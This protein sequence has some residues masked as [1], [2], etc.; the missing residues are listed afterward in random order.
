MIHRIIFL[1]A[2]SP[3]RVQVP[4]YFKLNTKRTSD[5]CPFCIWCGCSQRIRA[6]KLKTTDNH[7][8]IHAVSNRHIGVR[9]KKVINIYTEQI[10]YTKVII[11]NKAS[12]IILW[13]LYCIIRQIMVK[14]NIYCVLEVY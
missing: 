6:T 1:Y 8:Y 12:T 14:Y 10:V 4:F 13:T 3:L 9:K 7:T 2:A 5:G 11:F